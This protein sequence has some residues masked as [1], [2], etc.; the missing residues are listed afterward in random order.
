M[1]NGA[2]EALAYEE[3]YRASLDAP[4]AFWRE[5][6]QQIDWFEFPERIASQDAN[7]VTRWFEGGKLNTAWLALDRH[8]Q[9]GFGDRCA[10]IYDSPAAGTQQRFSYAELLHRVEKVAGGLVELGVEKGDRVVIYMPM[11]PEAAVA[12]LAC[13]RIGAIHS[14]VF[15]RLRSAGAGLAHRRRQAQ[16]DPLRLVWHRV[17]QHHSLQAAAGRSHR[18]RRYETGSH[19]D[20]AAP[21]VR[22]GTARWPR[23][24]LACVGGSERGSPLHASGRL[25]SALHP[26]YLRHHGQTEGRGARQR[27][28]RRSAALQHEGHLRLRCRRRVLGVLGCRLGGGPFLHRLRPAAEGLR[29]RALRGQARAHARRPVPSGG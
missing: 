26:L 3:A 7:G 24:R 21:A 27:R 17:R 4:E 9:A 1:A 2:P 19:R 28:P 14:V 12:M 10:L 5:A 11:I 8:V 6:A 13:A 22:S 20:P 25:G 23:P 18:T 15:G 16:G 29:E